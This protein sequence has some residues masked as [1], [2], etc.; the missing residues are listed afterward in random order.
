MG[1]VVKMWQIINGVLKP[2]ETTLK[3]EG[4][5]EPYDL[6][7]WLASNP[8]IIGSDIAIIGRQVQT[9]SGPLDLIG[10]DKT[11]NVVIVELKRDRLPREALAQAI[12]YA[13]DVADWSLEKISGICS[14]YAQ[15]SLEELFEEKFPDIELEN[16]S[17][18]ETQRIVLIGFSIDASL[19]RMIDWLVDKYGISI[20]ASVLSYV[21]TSS[22]DELLAKTSIISE[23]LEQTKVKGQKKFEIPMSDEPGEYDIEHLKPLLIEYLSKPKITNQRIR[24]ILIPACLQKDVLTRSELKKEFNNHDPNIDESRSGYYLTAISSQMG[25]A[26]NDFLRQIIAYE[27]PNF[28]WE[29]DNFSIRKQYRELVK[30]V[31]EELKPAVPGAG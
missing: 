13:S 24:D 20:N 1:T 17:V 15:K 21:K 25:M 26:K 12:D 9:K 8:E 10:I 22:G 29:K 4:H 2:V 19:E 18:N 7:P 23:E 5:K 16:L 31:L 27:Y 30:Q 14:D 6:E 3:G 11:G 28:T